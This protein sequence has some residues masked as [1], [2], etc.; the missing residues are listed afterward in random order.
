MKFRSNPRLILL[1][2]FCF[3]LALTL[4]SY[5]LAQQTDEDFR[6]Q[7]PLVAGGSVTV[8]NGRGD[9]RVEGWDK[10]E[11]LLEA[12]KY[13]EGD[14]R[15]RAEWLRETKIRFEGDDHHRLVKV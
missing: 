10:A 3:S 9:V 14:D 5:A 2:L 12:H 7:A 8:E 11:I 4:G 6:Q 13:F 1:P 15:D